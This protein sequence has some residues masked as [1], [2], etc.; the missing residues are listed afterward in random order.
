MKTVNADFQNYEVPCRKEK[1]QENFF[2]FNGTT[3]FDK[4]KDR[5]QNSGNSIGQAGK[6]EPLC[7]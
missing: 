6:K 3:M 2:F 1:E 5:K 4:L 7:F